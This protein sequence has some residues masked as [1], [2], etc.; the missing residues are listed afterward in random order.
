MLIRIVA[1]SMPA[2]SSF[3]HRFN[4]SFER[5]CAQHDSG[6]YSI[7][8]FP[9]WTFHKVH[10]Q[11]RGKVPNTSEAFV[12]HSTSKLGP[13]PLHHDLDVASKETHLDLDI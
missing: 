5:K 8:P 12:Q 3:T 2:A 1:S 6:I 9:V 10:P 11:Q 13:K 4:V 7:V